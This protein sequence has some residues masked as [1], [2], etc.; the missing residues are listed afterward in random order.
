MNS[1]S[2]PMADA[3]LQLAEATKEFEGLFAEV[4]DGLPQ[5]T[6]QTGETYTEI[7]NWGPRHEG[8]MPS[9]LDF[10]TG[11]H[12]AGLAIHAHAECAIAEWLSEACKFSQPLMEAKPTLYWRTRPEIDYGHIDVYATNG[13]F[14]IPTWKVYSRLLISSKPRIV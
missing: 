9:V 1:P 8:A 4:V 5:S 3:E 2:G 11:K 10:A 13:L 7:Y 6:S 14:R 12:V